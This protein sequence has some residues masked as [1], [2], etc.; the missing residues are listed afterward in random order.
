MLKTGDA[1]DEHKGLVDLRTL[2]RYPEQTLHFPDSFAP[3]A[4][5]LTIFFCF[6]QSLL[7]FKEDWAL[8]SNK[9]TDESEERE[10]ARD[11]GNYPELLEAK[12]SRD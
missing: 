8:W 1:Q 10:D 4:G 11:E 9:H 12:R 6:M 5:C 2:K 3:V 7:L